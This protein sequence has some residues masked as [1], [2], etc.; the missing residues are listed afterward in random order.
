MVGLS[1]APG[2]YQITPGSISRFM[3]ENLG[4]WD[5]RKM[6]KEVLVDF[7]LGTANATGPLDELRPA[8]AA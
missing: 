7:L 8:R 4:A 1:D 2:N 5:H 3:R 6:R